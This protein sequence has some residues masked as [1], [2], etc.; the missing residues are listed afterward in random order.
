VDRALEVTPAARAL[1]ASL[2]D[3]AGL[4]PPASLAM[5]EAVAEYRR[6]RGSPE[7]WMLGRFV[8]PA[9]RLAE[10]AGAVGDSAA[11]EPWPLSVLPGPDAAADLARALA[12]EREAGARVECV[13]LK[14]A[15]PAELETALDAVAGR[16]A[17]V[18]LPA[19]AEHGPLLARLKA[20]GARAKLRTGGVT[21][22]AI[23]GPAPVARFLRECARAGVPFKATAGLHHAVRAEHA[24]SYAPAA[25]RAKMHGFLNLFTAAALAR[26]GPA[27]DL[28]AVLREEDPSA[29][30]LEADGLAWRGVRASTAALADCRA[31]FAASFGSC[32][33]A[34]P[35]AELRTLGMIS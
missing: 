5:A 21:A 6:W 30:V 11:D 3:Y 23:P 20:R 1:L 10:L 17:Y 24:L 12:F 32:S 31:T 18:E 14:A 9:A 25:P 35:V 27:A 28:E 2:V 8:V 19:D 34:E 4:F 29:F 22:E 15:G 7:S 16:L 33:F 13:E 26:L